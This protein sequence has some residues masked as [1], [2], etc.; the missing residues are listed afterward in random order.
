M[1]HR[2]LEA[3]SAIRA[4]FNGRTQRRVL[5]DDQWNQL[6]AFPQLLSLGGL[7]IV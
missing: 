2:P 7:R 3:P 5:I 6:V 4:L 1:P